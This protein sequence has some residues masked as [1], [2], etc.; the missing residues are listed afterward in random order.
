MRS[1]VAFLAVLAVTTMCFAADWPRFRGPDGTGITDDN[2]LP[3]EWDKDKNVAWKVELPKCDVATS[4][5]IVVGDRIFIAYGVAKPSA[6][7]HV[8][9]LSKADGKTLW[10]AKVELG[11]VKS[12]DGRGGFAAP[13]P[14][15]DGK[16]VFAVFASAAVACLD[17]D[18]KVV[19]RKE[20]ANH[21]FDVVMGNSPL[22][23]GDTLIL[24]NDQN[25]N[26]S[27]FLAFDK[28]T[29][30]IK[31]AEPRKGFG[32]AHSTPI[33][34]KIDGKEQIIAAGNKAIQGID[35]ATGKAI[36]SCAAPGETSSPACDG[37]LIYVDTGRGDGGVAVQP[38]AGAEA[39]G[40][41][42]ANFKAKSDL[43]S[44]VVLGDF[45][46]RQAGEI[47][48][49]LKLA[50]GE[51]VFTKTVK[52]IGGSSSP[53][54]SRDGKVYVGTSG[55]CYVFKAG[56]DGELLATNKLGDASGAS[57]AVADG[58]IYFRGTKYLWCVG[59]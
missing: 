45:V 51:T 20:L 33:V 34:V 10:D 41:V 8:L 46:Y 7:N 15:S 42:K 23:W 27:E 49:C 53:F 52:G 6:E 17:M 40:T 12:V 58:R 38:P 26:K 43:G 31:I 19:W 56:P 39:K 47:F 21:Q 14:C 22:L 36:W 25:G 3:T 59:K 30:E 2:S 18:G 16:N 35:P 48:Q 37:G 29:G 55:T 13:T 1:T 57:A 4:S 9:C 5:P 24:I 11:P 32:M 50:T 54:A 28:A 44:P